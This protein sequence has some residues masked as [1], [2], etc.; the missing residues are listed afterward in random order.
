[1]ASAGIRLTIRSNTVPVGIPCCHHMLDL[2]SIMAATPPY[3]WGLGAQLTTISAPDWR[4]TLRMKEM[5]RQYCLGLRMRPELIT[6][7]LQPRLLAA[8][9]SLPS[10]R[11]IIST[12]NLSLSRWASIS[13]NTRSAPPSSATWLTMTIR[14]PDIW[15]SPFFLGSDL[16]G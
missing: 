5:V 2:P 10:D 8:S 14:F 11:K 13:I 3:I 1:M 12:W 6:C 7:T 16:G 15:M 9:A 4:I